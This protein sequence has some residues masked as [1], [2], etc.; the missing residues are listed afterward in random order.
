MAFDFDHTSVYARPYRYQ[1]P[2]GALSALT[3][4][5]I[6]AITFPRKFSRLTGPKARRPPR[7]TL[8][9]RPSP[10]NE[11]PASHPSKAPAVSFNGLRKS[12]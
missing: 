4:T 3:T 6:S 1:F 10:T 7:S 8:W 9:V 5:R 12:K 2:V 11:A